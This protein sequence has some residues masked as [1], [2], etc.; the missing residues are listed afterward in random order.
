MSK[1]REVYASLERHILEEE[2]K[3]LPSIG[4]VRSMLS[5]HEEVEDSRKQVRADA[6]AAVLYREHSVWALPARV[7]PDRAP[8]RSIVERVSQRG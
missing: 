4:K 3:I 5:L 2:G 6:H 8:G 1:V 7:E